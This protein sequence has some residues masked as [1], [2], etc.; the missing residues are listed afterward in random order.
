MA[1]MTSLS[2]EVNLQRR[3][4]GTVALLMQEKSLKFS[5]GFNIIAGEGY[6][7]KEHR[8]WTCTDNKPLVF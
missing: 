1:K 4:L 2:S 8:T 7:A 5:D 3:M 6:S